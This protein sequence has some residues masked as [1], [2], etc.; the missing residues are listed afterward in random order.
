MSK[1]SHTMESFSRFVI[2]LA[3]AA[4]ILGGAAWAFAAFGVQDCHGG[5][6]CRSSDQMQHPHY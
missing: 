5:I 3:G 4:A 2:A 1:S 6:E